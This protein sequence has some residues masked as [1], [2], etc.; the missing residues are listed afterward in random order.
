MSK[1][2]I[3][4]DGSL[5]EFNK[6]KI[7]KAIKKAFISTNKTFKDDDITSLVNEIIILINKDSISVEEIQ[8]LVEKLLMDNHYY[9]VARNYI[10]YREER[11]KFRQFRYALTKEVPSYN[12]NRVLKEI[13]REFNSPLYGLDKLLYKYL[14]KK[15]FK[16]NEDERLHTLI[17]C[18]EELIS[19]E[20]P[21]WDNIASRLFMVS[22]NKEIKDNLKKYNLNDFKNRLNLYVS[23]YHYDKD[24]LIKYNDD[25]IKTLERT[26]NKSNDKLLSFS[27]IKRILK[28]YLIKIN[29]EDYIETIQEFY[30]LISLTLAKDNEDKISDVTTYYEKLS[31]QLISLDSPLVNSVLKNL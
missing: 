2:I 27:L 15:I 20:A 1:M 7:F 31:K 6:D 30:L 4:R 11:N 25:E 24:L 10:L 26:I 21:Y 28:E 16:M 12:L 18:A 17:I 13:Q 8:N 19:S 29:D 5:E 22:F 3:K 23:K 14:S 9:D